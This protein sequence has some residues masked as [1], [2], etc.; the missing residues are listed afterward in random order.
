MLSQEEFRNL[1]HSQ[2][3]PEMKKLERERFRPVLSGAVGALALLILFFNW[4]QNS[5]GFGLLLVIVAVASWYYAKLLY[6]DYRR[7]YKHKVVAQVVR[8]ANPEYKFFY[9]HHVP[10]EM[11]IKGG[12]FYEFP[13][14]YTGDDYVSGTVEDI[15]FEFSEIK[16]TRGI[17][18]EEKDIFHGL[19]LRMTFDRHIDTAVY[20]FPDGSDMER[21]SRYWGKQL[22]DRGKRVRMT[23]DRFER[24]FSVFSPKEDQARALLSPDMIH[25]VLELQKLIDKPI[26]L[27]FIGRDV[28]C[29]IPYSGTIFE[30]ELFDTGLTPGIVRDIYRHFKLVERII[31]LLNIDPVP[32]EEDDSTAIRPSETEPVMAPP[33]PVPEPEAIELT[34]EEP[35]EVPLPDTTLNLPL[36]AKQV[37]DFKDHVPARDLISYLLALYPSIQNNKEEV[38][39]QELLVT[40]L[41]ESFSS[42]PMEMDPSWLSISTIPERDKMYRRTK[43]TEDLDSYA[44]PESRG[45]SNL[46]FTEEVLKFQIA[47][48]YKMRGNQLEND[49]KQYGVASETGT[50][51]YNFDPLSNM[52]SGIRQLIARNP[53]SADIDWSVIG[54][55]FQLGRVNA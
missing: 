40:L 12:L 17:G 37:N 49:M 8:L 50:P 55:I 26:Q 41:S 5:F 14:D 48:L 3:E 35:V 28:Y 20:L 2:F 36:L 42:E 24:K 54:L 51:W 30:P 1:Y 11:F 29:A 39:T 38:L 6:R 23:S 32:V 13:Q 33:A 15:S 16:T 18:Q 34:E 31:S 44:K 43:N 27:S 4:S 19:F 25:T 10:L 47:E 52:S 53:E 21:G 45:W 46:A 22:E 9:D 7:S